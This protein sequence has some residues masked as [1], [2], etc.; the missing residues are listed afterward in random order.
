MVLTTRKSVYRSAAG[1]I[2]DKVGSNLHGGKIDLGSRCLLD[3][4]A[5]T[6]NMSELPNRIPV[7]RMCRSYTALIQ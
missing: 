7:P 1:D 5:P 4:L 2:L 3:F 6:F